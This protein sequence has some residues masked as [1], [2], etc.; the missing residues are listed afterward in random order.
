MNDVSKDIRAYLYGLLNGNVTFNSSTVPVLANPRGDTT[1]PYILI[2]SVSMSDI[3]LK[4]KF[5]ATYFVSIEIHSRFD[6]DEGGGQDDIEDIS[7]TVLG[8]VRTRQATSDFGADTM[9]L[10]KL[11]STIDR[12]DDDEQYHYFLKMLTFECEVFED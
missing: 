2:K 10:F 6:V 3:S 7:N 5:G 12:E 8:L 1:Y 4:D 9:H 11:A